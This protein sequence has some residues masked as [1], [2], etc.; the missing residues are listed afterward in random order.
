VR[1]KHQI[2]GFLVALFVASGF[3]FL[4]IVLD[5]KIITM[6]DFNT[7][8]SFTFI[9]L[10]VGIIVG[11]VIGIKTARK[12]VRTRYPLASPDPKGD[13]YF[14]RSSIPRPIHRDLREHP[15]YFEKR[16]KKNRDDQRR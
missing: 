13:I 9:F 6:Y 16:K 12:G 3:T 4:G 7:F 14:P 8:G 5:F 15:E 11:G 2:I 10:C 1:L